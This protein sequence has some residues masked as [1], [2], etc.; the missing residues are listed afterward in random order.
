M[1]WL[2]P[3]SPAA[4]SARLF[5]PVNAQAPATGDS[6]RYPKRVRCLIA[7]CGGEAATVVSLFP[8]L[9]QA[10]NETCGC[11][12]PA[13]TNILNDACQR[14]LCSLATELTHAT[15]VAADSITFTQRLIIRLRYSERVMAR[16]KQALAA[17]SMTIVEAGADNPRPAQRPTYRC[18]LD[19]EGAD[20]G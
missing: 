11:D 20:V 13:I 2:C 17:A 16:L 15:G 8:D 3:I 6:G 19:L 12:T 7:G 4:N 18:L 10:L 9:A 1:Q 5:S 14:D